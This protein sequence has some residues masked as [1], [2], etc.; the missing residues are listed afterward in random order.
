MIALKKEN[1][2]L[3]RVGQTARSRAVCR[4]NGALRLALRSI[5]RKVRANREKSYTRTVRFAV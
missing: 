1:P 3:R 5:S 4:S 2:L